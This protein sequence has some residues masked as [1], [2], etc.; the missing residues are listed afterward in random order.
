LLEIYTIFSPYVNYPFFFYIGIASFF[1][2]AISTLMQKKITRIL[3]FAS[4]NQ[5]G[6]VFIG[7]S[8]ENNICIKLSFIYF[9][10]Y[11]IMLYKFCY[12]LENT[13]LI[14]AGRRLVYMTDLFY[15]YNSRHTNSILA[16]ILDF[17]GF[18]PSILFLGKLGIIFFLVLSGHSFYAF[19]VLL[20]S[21]ISTFYYL[22]LIKNLYFYL[23]T[24]SIL[25]KIKE[26]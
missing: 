23:Q 7:F 26:D 10:F 16:T 18:P 8:T 4:V 19:I 15:F 11:C 9:F 2:G 1:L 14:G 20:L 6:L 22:R 24:S 3:A 5:I 13:I 12:I 25:S 21:L 17:G